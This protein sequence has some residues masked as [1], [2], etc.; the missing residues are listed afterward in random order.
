[1][2]SNVCIVHIED[3]YQQMK[4]FPSR[5][6]D[7]IEKYWSDKTGNDNFSKIKEEKGNS[8]AGDAWIVFDIPC[9][10]NSG[11]KFRYILISASKISPE[12]ASYIFE[13]KYFIIDVLRPSSDAQ[14]L[15][16]TGNDS[17]ASARENGGSDTNITFFTACQ[18]TDLDALKRDNPNV[19]VIP[20][21]RLSELNRLLSDII[22][23][24]MADG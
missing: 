13:R 11:Q 2:P 9:P 22:Q 17:I 8:D 19:R 23:T 20:K 5:M 7:Y 14:R 3:E 21:S 10:E 16:V 15:W 12:I 1:M 24:S 4:S 6:K 18:G